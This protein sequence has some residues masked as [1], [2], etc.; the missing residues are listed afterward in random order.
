MDIIQMCER[1]GSLLGII[2]FILYFPVKKGILKAREENDNINNLKEVI[3]GLKEE[4]TDLWD[5][6]HKLEVEQKHL[7]EMNTFFDLNINMDRM[8]F[9]AVILCEYRKDCPIIKKREELNNG[10]K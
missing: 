9:N 3:N 1:F 5:R 2:A 7:N 6:I 10:K 4:R 8:A